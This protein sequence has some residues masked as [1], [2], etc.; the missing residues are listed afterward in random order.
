MISIKIH[1]WKGPRMSFHGVAIPFGI[2]EQAYGWNAA[3]RDVPLTTLF[4]ICRALLTHLVSFIRHPE[5]CTST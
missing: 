4:T 3:R 2:R 5:P 1:D